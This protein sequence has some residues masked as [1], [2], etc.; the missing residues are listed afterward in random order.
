[1]P[2]D[3]GAW[4]SKFFTGSISLVSCVLLARDAVLRVTERLRK[5]ASQEEFFFASGGRRLSGVW[6]AGE[7]AA[8][9]VLLCHGIGETVAHWS[10]VQ[11]IL[12]E[13][14][15]GSMVF[16]YSGYG[17]SSGRISAEN[18]DA[19][20][21]SA[22][23]ELHRRVGQDRPVFVLGF[24]LGSGIAASGAGGLSPAPAGLFLCEAFTT[25]REAGASRGISR[26]DCS[27]IL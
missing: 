20:L 24:S 16:N 5:D 25:F 8:P 10:A 14:G 15:V 21:V 2:S 18:C 9:V 4:R 11:A 12:R 19:D 22:Y 13:R 3:A 23:A 7:D 26:V 17:A 6:V 27:R 1:M